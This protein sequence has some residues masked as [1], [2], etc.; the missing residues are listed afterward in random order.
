MNKMLIGTAIGTA[1]GVSLA[2]L[3]KMAKDRGYIDQVSDS[4]SDLAYKAK[5][6][7]KTLMDASTN[8]VEYLKDQAEQQLKKGKKKLED[9]ADEMQIQ[10]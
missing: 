4:V 6:K 3:A 5:R 8:E 1:V 7:A 9:L 2:V 10:S